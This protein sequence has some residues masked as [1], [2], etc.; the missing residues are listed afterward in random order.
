MDLYICEKPSQGRDLARVLHCNKKEDG[1]L[2]NNQAT[3]T[4]CLGHLLE[5]LEPHEYDPKYK[6]WCI[7]DLPIIP[8][9][10]NYKVKSAVA[11]QYKIVTNLIKQANCVYIAT[12]Y[13]R[14]GEA[15]ARTLLDRVR[16]RGQIKRVCLSALDDLSIK[17]ALASVKE[18]N[19]TIA[20]YYSAQA[21]LRADWVVG[22]NLSR[23]FTLLGQRSGFRG[24]IPVGRVLTPTVSLVVERDLLIKNFVPTP[25]FELKVLVLTEKGN[26]WAFWQVPEHLADPD[27]HCIKREIVEQIAQEIRDQL[28]I[29]SNAEKKLVKE[30]VPLPFDLTSLQQYASKKWGYT[31]QQTLDAA[32]SL[33]ETHKATTYPRS[34]CR[35]LPNSQ[36]ADVPQ[37]LDSMVQADPSIASIVNEAQQSKKGKCF[38]ETIDSAHHAIIPT[39]KVASLGAMSPIERNIY[40]AIRAFYLIQFFDDAEFLR[41]VIEVTCHDHKFIAKGKILVKEG[42]RKALASLGLL[43]MQNNNEEK[44]D[45]QENEAELPNVQKGDQCKLTNPEV[46]NKET[47]PPPHFTEATLLAA[48]ENIGKYVQ[49][50]KF[51]KILKET[52]GIGTPATRANIIENAIK[53][54]YLKRNKKSI[55]ATDKAIA[56][57]PK[58]PNGMRSAGLTAAWEQEL[59]K[60]AHNNE[61]TDLFMANIEKWIRSMITNYLTKREFVIENAAQLSSN[62]TQ[63]PKAKSTYKRET[64]YNKSS[65][66]K[67]APQTNPNA[68]LCPNCQKPMVLRTNKLKGNQFWGCSGFP[69]CRGVLPLQNKN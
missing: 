69:Q 10:Y 65:T 48:M 66:Q 37:I 16:Y 6:K 27:H 2:S 21:R 63:A 54:E 17:R 18:G 24:V 67:T 49:E 26:F 46:L 64:T 59:D 15:I 4:W 28:G 47:T 19:E 44:K 52:A 7:E 38:K 60:I 8:A 30:S 50:E 42:Y 51:K 55:L 11:K 23:L 22:M 1:A 35:D 58:L 9:H 61:S 31:A 53:H 12:D 3:V 29:I 68:P 39:M 33:Y 14:E 45:D 43:N 13:D 40:N 62:S 41:S 5:L 57:I 32:Q 20:L 25:Y 56:I 34:D 36:F